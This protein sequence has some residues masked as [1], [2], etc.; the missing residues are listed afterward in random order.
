MRCGWCRPQAVKEWTEF[1]SSADVEEYEERDRE[2]EERNERMREQRAEDYTE[3]GYNT[4]HPED[5]TKVN[6]AELTRSFMTFFFNGVK[7]SNNRAVETQ[8]S[9]EHGGEGEAGDE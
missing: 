3:W 5:K 7:T 8:N 1:L 4:S 9:T 6:E 2:R